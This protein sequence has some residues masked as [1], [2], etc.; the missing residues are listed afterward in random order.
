MYTARDILEDKHG[1]LVLF[2]FKR[3]VRLS[4]LGHQSHSHTDTHTEG[5]R[6]RGSETV[7]RKDELRGKK[8]KVNKYVS[9]V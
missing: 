1:C 3:S 4:V 6:E 2:C 7:E 9:S 8:Q 5:E